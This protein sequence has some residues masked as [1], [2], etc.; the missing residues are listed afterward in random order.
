V[1]APLLPKTPLCDH[2]LHT[3]NIHEFVT[4]CNAKTCC[5]KKPLTLFIERSDKYVRERLK[6]APIKR[7]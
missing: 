3:L 4:G 7:S 6:T 5:R 1:D 2:F